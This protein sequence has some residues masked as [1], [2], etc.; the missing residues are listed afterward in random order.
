M[1]AVIFDLDGTII[2]SL[3][4]HMDSYETAGKKLGVRIDSEKV[5]PLV[6]K[7][8]HDIMK[9]LFPEMSEDKISRITKGKDE[10]FQSVSWKNVEVMED[11]ES[12]VKELKGRYKLAIGTSA[13]IKDAELF[14]KKF[15]WF[16]LFDVFVGRED[17]K[18]GK[19]APDIYLEAAR[20]LGVDP[21]DCAV[22]GDAKYD[23]IAAKSAKMKAF[24]VTTG[25]T[26][27]FELR[28]A[29][30]DMVYPSLT[31]AAMRL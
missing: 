10:V 19:P 7:T 4:A 31:E 2:N 28:K 21:R 11:A 6:G 8:A 14:S 29:G 15:A 13:S 18:R 1:E 20:R 16:S 30:A 22:V 12:V 9:G 5:K 3:K 24:G 17:A 25:V 27:E 26:D 23:M